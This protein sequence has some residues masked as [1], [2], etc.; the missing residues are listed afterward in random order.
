MKNIQKMKAAILV[1]QKKPLR[2]SEVSLPGELTCGQ[3]LVKVRYSG[4]CGSQIGEIEGVKGPDKYLPHLLGHEGSGI[5]MQ[6]GLGVTHVAPGNHVVLHWMKG[7]GIE[8]APPFYVWNDK[9]LNAGWITTFN[10][11]AIV[12]ENRCTVIPDDFSLKI[13][14][15]FGC[16]VTTGLG[17]IVHDAKLTIGESVAV[18]GA[19]GVGLNM[20]QGAKLTSA[21]PIIAID[22]FENRLELARRF[23]ATH[24][25][26]TKKDDV[27]ASIRQIVGNGG[28]DVAIDNTGVPEVIEQCYQLA[29]PKG[30][31]ILVGVPKAGNTISIYSLPMHFG[32]TVKG[33]HGGETNP[34]QD[35]NRYRG[36]CNAGILKLDE[37]I[38]HEIALA[39]INDAVTSM[40]N[41]SIAGRCLIRFEGE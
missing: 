25:I 21:Y 1:E 33:S 27:V 11:Y 39:D 19:G 13:A 17:V 4:I 40:K 32:K 30:R 15:L 6:I 34:S 12:S 36:L 9:P 3:V 22:L 29:G 35:I 28:L 16:A 10:D 2:I 24:T 38:T 23:G 20:I 8:A 31:V 41:G 37:L 14:A 18:F 26:N 7:V 5:V